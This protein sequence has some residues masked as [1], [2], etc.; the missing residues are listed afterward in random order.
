[1][2]PR[3]YPQTILR[4]VALPYHSITPPLL[5][6]ACEVGRMSLASLPHYCLGLGSMIL[7]NH[8]NEGD[9]TAIANPHQKL[10]N[11]ASREKKITFKSLERFPNPLDQHHSSPNPNRSFHPPE[12]ASRPLPGTPPL[13]LRRGDGRPGPTA[14]TSKLCQAWAAASRS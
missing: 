6:E 5:L 10:S 13:S 11:L 7:N 14:G 2:Y 12:G 8:G 9:W 1:M 3:A 4:L